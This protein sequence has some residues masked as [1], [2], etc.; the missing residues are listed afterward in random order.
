MSLFY[1][2]A[3]DT[4]VSWVSLRNLYCLGLMCREFYY[5]I[6]RVYDS[7]IQ[8][9]DVD[10]YI[11]VRFDTQKTSLRGTRRHQDGERE[12]IVTQLH[13]IYR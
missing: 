6:F 5:F 3:H 7:R 11:F 10:I 4:L 2:W 9:H 8:N 12:V 13:V 1:S